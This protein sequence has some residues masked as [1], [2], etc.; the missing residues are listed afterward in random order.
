VSYRCE[1]LRTAPQAPH[2]H[3]FSQ[4]AYG[5]PQPPRFQGIGV[6]DFLPDLIMEM[7]RAI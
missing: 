7:T 1:H 2:Q 3:G 6:R 5:K 4:G